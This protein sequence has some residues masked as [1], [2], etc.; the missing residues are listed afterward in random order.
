MQ[1][2][3]PDEIRINN[4]RDTLTLRYDANEFSLSAEYLR[5]YSPSAEVRG[6]GVGQEK[7]QTGKRLVRITEITAAGNYAV[8]IGFSDGHDSGLYDWDYLY[9]LAHEY[10][11]RWQNYLDRVQAAGASRDIDNS[12]PP[13]THSHGHGCGGG[14][15]TH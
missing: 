7:L 3:I 12:V 2:P 4:T 8:K 6:H 11:A 13:K 10:D 5:V 14:C 15:G 1:N 9:A